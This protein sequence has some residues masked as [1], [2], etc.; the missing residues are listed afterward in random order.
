MLCLDRRVLIGLG[1]VGLG[2]F[3]LKPSWLGATIPLLVA[4]ACPLSM[5]IMMRRDAPAHTTG[6]ADGDV[7]EL[8]A[9]IARLRAEIE[10]Q[11]NPKSQT[12]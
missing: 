12:V 4:L 11:P 6:R 5:L 10:T 8:R 2:V 3:L 1:A 9:E 7:D